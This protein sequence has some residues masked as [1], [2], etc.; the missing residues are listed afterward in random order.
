[1]AEV[2][3]F[4]NI[5]SEYFVRSLHHIQARVSTAVILETRERVTIGADQ[6][7]FPGSRGYAM[8]EFSS[9]QLATVQFIFPSIPRAGQYRLV[10]RYN[11]L[12]FSRRPTLLISQGAIFHQAR[13]SLH[14]NCERPCYS[15]AINSMNISE[16]AVFD[17]IEGP[18]AVDMRLEAINV[19]I[20]SVIA[21]PEE[22]YSADIP[23]GEQFIQE[24]NITTGMFRCLSD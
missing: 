17:L 3:I 9:S 5:A 1:M 8:L 19:L 2:D 11:Q 6:R 10:F 4:A 22:F 14:T 24:C 7:L 21:V 18:L 23:G 12:G 16:D 13:V 20:D 15:T